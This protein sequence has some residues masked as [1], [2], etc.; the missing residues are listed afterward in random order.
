MSFAVTQMQEEIVFV[1]GPATQAVLALNVLL[2]L[3]VSWGYLW[4]S[5]V[6]L[7]FDVLDWFSIDRNHSEL[8]L[9]QFNQ[10]SWV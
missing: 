3:L 10:V 8:D 1:L 4:G 2:S 7:V 9:S 5:A 6:E